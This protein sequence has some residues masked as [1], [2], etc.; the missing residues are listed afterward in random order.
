MDLKKLAWGL[1]LSSSLVMVG[2]GDDDGGGGGTDAGGGTDSGGGDMPLPGECADGACDFVVNNL[3]IPDVAVMG[4]AEVADG[5]NVDGRESDET[6]AEGCNIPDFTG[7]D[8]R[9]GVDNQLASLKPTLDSF[10]DGGL[11]ATIDGALAD[12]SIILL[13][14]LT[15]ADTTN[16]SD[17][18]LSVGLGEVPGGGAPMLGGDGR[19]APGQTFDAGDVAVPVSARTEGGI[20]RAGPL[21]LPLSIPFDETTSIDL[22]INSAEVEANVTATGLSN[23][24]IG[25]ELIIEELITTVMAVAGDG[26]PI[27]VVRNTLESVADLSPDA[28]GVCQSVSVGIVFDAVPA[29]VN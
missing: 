11:D 13:M 27:D 21:N 16:D 8:G 7:S 4:G 5:F 18:M 24:L 15:G 3:V 2:C 6:D 26:I 17:V 25:G 1:L 20:L 22:N 28:D 9:T 19:L 23:G 12:G 10:V 14:R 29:T